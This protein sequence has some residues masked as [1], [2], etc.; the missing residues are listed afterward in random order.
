ME[1]YFNIQQLAKYLRITE[2][3]A[4]NLLK[5]GKM[6]SV[7]TSAGVFIF[8]KS[9]IDRWLGERIGKVKALL[10]NEETL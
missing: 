3:A 8:K 6:P 9:D 7:K 2:K 10:E 4:N 1:S 5:S